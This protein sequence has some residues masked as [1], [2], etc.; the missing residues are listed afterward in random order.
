MKKILILT[1]MANRDAG[2]DLMLAHE[3]KKRGHIVWTHT[4]LQHEDRQSICIIKPDIVY[5]PEMRNE[6][7]LNLGL[8]VKKWGGQVVIKMCEFTIT[9]ESLPFISEEYKNAIFGNH[10]INP[11]C[12]IVLAWGNKSV[13][14]VRKYSPVSAEKV[15]GCGGI[16]FDHYFTEV[17]KMERDSNKSILFASGFA[18]ADRNPNFSMPEAKLGDQLHRDLVEIDARGRSSWIEMLRAFLSDDRFKDW[19][20]YFK[21]HCGEKPEIYHAIFKERIKFLSPTQPAFLSLEYID[22]V[23]H[24]GSTMAYEAHLRNKPAFCYENVCQDRV[25]S[26]IS[27][28]C[29][30]TNDLFDSIASVEFGKTNANPIIIKNMDDNYYGPVDGKAYIRAADAIDSLPV[31]DP[32]IPDVWPVTNIFRS[33]DP[34]MASYV[35]NWY[36]AGCKNSYYLIRPGR[37]MVK[38]PYCGIGNVR[39]TPKQ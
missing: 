32:K 17:P 29:T 1:H 34:D 28:N 37:E 27:P 5:L 30:N 9:E 26:V 35:E 21:P 11:A 36:C 12:D 16:A 14:L 24:A 38:C 3:L 8:N 2:F 23:V 7:T 18:Y 22:V 13:E 10:N 15:I 39:N 20:V 33:T 6:F 4:F 19:S 31:C 25:V